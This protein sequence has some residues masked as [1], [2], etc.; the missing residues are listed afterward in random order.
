V[1][2]REGKGGMEKEIFSTE[3]APAA[4]GPYSQA[5]RAGTLIFL[6]GQLPIDR[7]TGL[8]AEGSIARQTEMILET[9]GNILEDAG[10]G[11]DRIVKVTVY[12]TDLEKFGEMNEA[13]ARYFPLSP[14]AR[15][16]V[17]VKSLPKGAAIEIEVVALA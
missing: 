14:P 9:V 12:M 4:I 11:V 3:R 8:L 6:S 10:S 5:V 15:S 16:A 7:S 17:G 13:Y 2:S 1:R